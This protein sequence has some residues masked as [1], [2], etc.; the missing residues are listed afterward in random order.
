MLSIIFAYLNLDEEHDDDE[1]DDEE[2][3][4]EEAEEEEDDE[5]DDHDH[6]ELVSCSSILLHMYEANLIV[7]RD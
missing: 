7:L 6:D 5:D 3:D 4:D 1:D 2:E